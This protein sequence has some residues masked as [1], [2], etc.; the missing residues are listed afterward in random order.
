MPHQP[1]GEYKD[2]EVA[3]FGTGDTDKT[4]ADFGIAL[5]P[6]ELLAWL[7]RRAAGSKGKRATVCGGSIVVEAFNIR[8]VPK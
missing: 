5:D 6:H 2:V 8:R 7:G 4:L 3:H 1:I